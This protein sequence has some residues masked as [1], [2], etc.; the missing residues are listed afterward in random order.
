MQ[1]N[2][3][4]LNVQYILFLKI[5]VLYP[6]LLQ[7]SIIINVSGAQHQLTLQAD[8]VFQVYAVVN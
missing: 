3:C 4:L 7:N 5:L 8:A 1:T 2:I 6:A